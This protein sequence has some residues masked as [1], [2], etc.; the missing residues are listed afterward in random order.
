MPSRLTRAITSSS[1]TW[2]WNILIRSSIES[3]PV[4]SCAPLGSDQSSTMCG[5]TWYSTLMARTASSAV[6]SSTAATPDDI[7]SSPENFCARPLHDF[8][9]LHAG[10]FLRSAGIDAGHFAVR[11][12][13]ANHQAVKKVVGAEVV[14]VLGFAG[15][16]VRSVDA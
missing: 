9:G 8:D 3:G 11:V 16:F 5:R 12:G 14:G 13:R 1:S 15:N 6:P 2:F 4:S 7:V 10:H